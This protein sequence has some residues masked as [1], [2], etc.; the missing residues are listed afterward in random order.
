MVFHLF[1]ADQFDKNIAD[2]VILPRWVMDSN[3]GYGSPNFIFYGPL[4][5]YLVALFNFVT[6]SP[7]VSLILAIWCSF[8]LSGI[9]MFFAVK[10]I[11]GKNGSLP[12][13]LLYQI[14]PFHLLNLY[15][16]GAYAELCA[17]AW[18]PL[19]I[20]F[21]YEIVSVQNEPLA[22]IGLSLSYSGLILT[23][24]VS[25][26][27]FTFVTGFYLVISY[28]FCRCGKALL[29]ALISLVLGLGISSLYLIPVIYER[30]F[31]Q[32]DYIFNYIFSDYHKNFLFLFSNFKA[33]MSPFYVSLHIAVVLEIFLFVALIILVPQSN[34]S[35][36]RKSQNA[37]YTFIFI[38][39]FFLTIPLSAPLWDIIPFFATLQFPWRWVSVMELSLCFLV[40]AT[41]SG[42]NLNH[43]LP[44]GLKA[45][46]IIYCIIALSSVSWLL[47]IKSD[48]THSQELLNKILMPEQVKRYTNLPKEYT[49]IWVSD[50]EKLV[51]GAKSVRVSILSGQAEHR[52]LRWHSESRIIGVKALTSTL[53]RISTSYYPGWEAEVD[54][55]KAAIRVEERTGAMLVSIPKGD[56]TLELVFG[57]TSLRVFARC[58]SLASLGALVMLAVFLRKKV[59]IKTASLI[60]SENM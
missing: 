45:R 55:R 20:L 8:F 34:N 27:I 1:Q 30:K 53:L 6:L 16:R 51:T 32:I 13:A 48:E 7:V 29:I 60:C 5:Y 26:F 25:A 14:L 10:K 46:S 52:V 23:H 19:I 17:Y 41:F 37:V 49:P 42:E 9:T 24:L 15:A 3:N 22:P 50:V 57:D 4:S 43:L 11:S 58:V 31:V 12:S 59:A 44:A 28:I 2:G 54:G 40:G 39:A 36:L 33:G 21:L 18:L 47:V 56:H 38:V 35:Q